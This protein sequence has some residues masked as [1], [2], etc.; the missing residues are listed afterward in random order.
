MVRCNQTLIGCVSREAGRV[1]CRTASGFGQRLRAAL[2]LAARQE[3][4]RPDATPKSS[5]HSINIFF[6]SSPGERLD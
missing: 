3:D 5:S 6:S 4:L 2:D 1:A